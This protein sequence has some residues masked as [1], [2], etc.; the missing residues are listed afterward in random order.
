VDLAN[1]D[2]ELG[3]KVLDNQAKKKKVVG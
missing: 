2:D 3:R 1:D